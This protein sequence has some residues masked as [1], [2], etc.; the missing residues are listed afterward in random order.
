MLQRNMTLS[1]A[2]VKSLVNESIKL[3]LEQN[4]RSVNVQGNCMY[5]GP[6]GLKCAIGHL[7]PDELYSPEMEGMSARMVIEGV[8]EIPLTKEQG[9]L[10]NAL[11]RSHDFAKNADFNES[12]NCNLRKYNVV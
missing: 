8:L 10:F 12:F 6:N 1:P 3:V 9:N 4:E 7:I 11:Q 2:S 5:R